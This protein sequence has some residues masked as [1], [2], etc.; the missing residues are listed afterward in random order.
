VSN[1]DHPC[2][3]SPARH[4]LGDFFFLLIDLMGSQW[5]HHSIARVRRR[6]DHP[7]PSSSNVVCL[8]ILEN[9]VRQG[10]LCLLAVKKWNE[11]RHLVF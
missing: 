7:P 11:S 6:G 9:M 2:R 5:S 4:R 1:N 8:S 3:M 10:I